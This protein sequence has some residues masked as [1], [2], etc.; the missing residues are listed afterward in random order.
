MADTL[1]GQE[2]RAARVGENAGSLP[3]GSVTG[4]TEVS[5][6][7]FRIANNTSDLGSTSH[8]A[9]SPVDIKNPLV[10]FDFALARRAIG[11]EF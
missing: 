2:K 3:F 7:Y 1:P 4:Y 11:T 10:R 9:V 5:G 6:R 8:R